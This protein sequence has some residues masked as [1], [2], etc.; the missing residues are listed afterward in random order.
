MT[1]TTD[2]LCVQLGVHIPVVTGVIHALQPGRA[3]DSIPENDELAAGGDV[4]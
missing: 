3:A 4:P 1:M 2:L